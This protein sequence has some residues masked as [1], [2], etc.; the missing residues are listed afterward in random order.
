[1]FNHYLLSKL[2]T[3]RLRDLY[4][5]R[6]GQDRPGGKSAGDFPAREAGVSTPLGRRGR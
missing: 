1:V 3:S 6:R 2:A 5:S 4:E